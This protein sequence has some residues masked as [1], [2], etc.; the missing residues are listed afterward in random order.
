MPCPKPAYGTL[1]QILTLALA[2]G[3]HR[4]GGA[5]ER[6]RRAGTDDDAPRPVHALKFWMVDP[7]VVLQNL[8]VD[9]GGLK[10]SYPGPPES[11]RLS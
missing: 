11:L 5:T 10:P 8:V 1:R 9:T 3:R 2:A 6:G 7:T 4:T